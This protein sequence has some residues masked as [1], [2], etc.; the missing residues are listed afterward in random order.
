MALVSAHRGGAGDDRSLEN[1]MIAFEAAIDAG[2]DY[3]EFDIRLTADL[4][5]VLAHDDVLSDAEQR[6]ISTHAYDEFAPGTL[7]DLDTLLD[8][9]A[10]TVGAHVD[11]K[12]RGE[13]VALVSHI[14]DRL[15]T[16]RVI[17]TTEQD[18]SVRAIRQWSRTE[19]P[20]L[21]VGLSSGPWSHDGRFIPRWKARIAACFPRLRIW[22]SGANLV[23]AHRTVARFSL[24][25]YA[26]R[27]SLPLVVWT[28]N[29]PDELKRWMNDPDTWIVTTNYPPRA[30]E[31]RK[32][33]SSRR[34]S[35]GGTPRPESTR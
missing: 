23:V 26:R 29:D 15:G 4:R 8:L 20:G 1:T 24:K 25:A 22:S 18:S 17:I 32:T 14:V 3:V 27:R 31:A 33:R 7:L 11:L 2:V 34:G 28:V 13:E 21:L 19:A 10:G 5:P 9:L 16:D 30:F 6:S 12:V 35:D